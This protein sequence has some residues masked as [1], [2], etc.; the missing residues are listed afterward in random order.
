LTE[1]Y[2]ETMTLRS[3]AD[4]WFPFGGTIPSLPFLPSL[5]RGSGG[6]THGKCG[7]YYARWSILAHSHS[8]AQS[9]TASGQF[10]KPEDNVCYC[11]T[12]IESIIKCAINQHIRGLRKRSQIQ[13]VNMNNEKTNKTFLSWAMYLLHKITHN[14]IEFTGS[15]TELSLS[16]ASTTT[17]KI[18]S[19]LLKCIIK[20]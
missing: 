9:T 15:E 14:I 4:P 7:C 2:D 10:L 3:V 5:W 12:L 13:Y 6:I 17:V 18:P 1:W 20:S 8:L 19:P 11:S 16:S